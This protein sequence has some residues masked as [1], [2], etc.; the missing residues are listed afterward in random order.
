MGKMLRKKKKKQDQKRNQNCN[1]RRNNFDSGSSKATKNSIAEENRDDLISSLPNEILCHIISF[2][3]FES[4]QQTIFLS[5]RW[6]VLWN[7]ALEQH[8]SLEDIARAVDGFLTRFDELDPLR[9]PRRLQFHSSHGRILFATIA[10]NKK[11][12][13]HSSM[14]KQDFPW[15]FEWCLNLKRQRL[16]HQPS[17]SSFFVKT[18]HL[19]SVSYLCSD[20][21][22]SIVSKFQFLERL[23]VTKCNGLRSLTIYASQKLQHLTVLDC[24]QLKSLDIVAHKLQSF[25]YR[26]LLPSFVLK[27]DF[28]VEDAML[29]VREGP[30]Y[31]WFESRDFRSLSSAITNAKILTLCEWTFEALICPCQSSGRLDSR[32]NQLKELWWIDSSIEENKIDALLT[33]LKSCPLLERLFIE[34]DP[35]SHCLPS[36][37]QWTKQVATDSRLGH[38]KVVILEGHMNQEDEILL[39]ER[40]LQIV[41][42]EPLIIARSHGNCVRSL[43]KIPSHQLK[44]QTNVKVVAPK[45]RKC[46][47]KFVEEEDFS[48]FCSKHA[49]V[50][51]D[52]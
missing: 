47:Y 20:A 36:T 41:N 37:R 3:P 1:R 34:I 51:K 48:E 19:T 13:L 44:W 42:T 24:P 15:P 17:P 8:G 26:G 14:G 21:V 11:L 12:H 25:R 10:A 50:G 39:V 46:S 40:L 27:H 35:A 29:D 45:G 16:I 22:S 30:G 23:M 52:F 2:L 49:H 9:H 4:A 43:V 38:L 28:F 33:F 6:R 32:F 31:A 5:T 18:L 7:T